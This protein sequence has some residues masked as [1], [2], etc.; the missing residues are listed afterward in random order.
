MVDLRNLNAFVIM[1][2]ILGIAKI[3][4]KNDE[5]ESRQIEFLQGE[6]IID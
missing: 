3:I 1:N 4:V 6:N 5:R 2:S